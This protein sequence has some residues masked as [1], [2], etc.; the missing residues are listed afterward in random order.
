MPDGP[1]TTETLMELVTRRDILV[2]LEREPATSRQIAHA[3]RSPEPSIKIV[4]AWMRRDGLVDGRTVDYGGSR[5]RVTEWRLPHGKRR[6]P[7]RQLRMV[8]HAERPAREMHRHDCAHET[9]CVTQVADLEPS[10][11]AC[12]CPAGCPH[13]V[14]VPPHVRI[15][16]AQPRGSWFELG[17]EP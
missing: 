1:I 16:L 4:L 11:A 15:A 12:E 9:A 3:L 10:A 13:L 2:I 8:A 7:R 17:G 6:G 5:G 14:P